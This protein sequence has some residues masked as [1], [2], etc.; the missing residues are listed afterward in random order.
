MQRQK[1]TTTYPILFLL[2][3]AS[4]HITAVTGVTPTV[5]ISKNGAAFA[6]PSG[7]VSEVANGI[8]MLA[9]NATDRNTLGT[10]AVHATATGA[11]A[12]D[13]LIEIVDYDPFAFGANL[14]AAVSSRLATASYTAPDNAGVAAI[15]AKTDNLP[16][17]PASSG[18]VA[19]VPAAV[20]TVSTR[21]LTSFGTLVNDIAT[22]VWGFVSRTINGGAVSITVTSPIL[23]SGD[24]ELI[25]G[26]DYKLADGRQLE[27]TATTWPVLTGATVQ[28]ISS[29]FTKAMTVVDAA[30][31]RLELEDT[32]TTGAYGSVTYKIFATLSNGNYVTLHRGTMAVR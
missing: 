19:A 11:D 16:A 28:F 32:D 6:A 4:D 9:G 29:R 3:S 10:L 5:T 25:A 20:W 22:A 30:T 2:V 15:K 12:V 18:D 21:A 31:V 8:Y 27:W 17:A 1:S 7:A 24:I 14:D 23:P 26:D 13:M